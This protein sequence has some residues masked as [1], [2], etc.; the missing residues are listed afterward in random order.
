[1]QARD[2]A[3]GRFVLT[4]DSRR[5][6]GLFACFGGIMVVTALYDLLIGAR[7]TDRLVGLLGGAATCLLTG[8]VFLEQAEAVVD[9]TERTITWRRRWAFQRRSGLLR[10]EDVD[11][12]FADR[13]LGDTGIPSRRIVLRT[14][15]GQTVP[16]TQGYA[17]DVD[18]AILASS[19]RI[20]AMLGP[21][22]SAP[23]GIAAALVAA[24]RTLEAITHLRETQ[25]L[26]LDAAKREVDRLR[27]R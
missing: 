26:S 25:G 19:E 11:V 20:A 17:P 6:S 18:G 8:I 23:A 5:W 3:N 22:S 7:G 15:D 14:K 9:P 12:V 1:M 4:Y 21:G 13:P 27:G 16:L 10:F 2:G 24:G